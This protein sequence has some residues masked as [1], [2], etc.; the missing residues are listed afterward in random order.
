MKKFIKLLSFLILIFAFTSCGKPS[1]NLEGK[2]SIR[3]VEYS[4]DG[5]EIFRNMSDVEITRKGDIYTIVAKQLEKKKDYDTDW[6]TGNTTYSNWNET[7]ND[8][9]IF[10]GKI[11][12]E[13][14]GKSSNYNLSEG[15]VIFYTLKNDDNVTLKI[16]VYKDVRMKEVIKNSKNHDI[17]YSREY[18]NIVYEGN[19]VTDYMK[20]FPSEFSNHPYLY[21]IKI[22]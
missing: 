9:F 17:I 20:I 22:K 18:E 3:K 11:I 15:E 21:V 8:N 13:A 2:Y 1:N 10:K 19:D 4:E 16:T 5:V 14:K 12:D 7:I 6:I